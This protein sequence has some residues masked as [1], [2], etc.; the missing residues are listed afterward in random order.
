[1]KIRFLRRRDIIRAL[2][3]PGAIGRWLTAPTAAHGQPY[4]KTPVGGASRVGAPTT[5]PIATRSVFWVGHSLVEQK[6][7]SEWGEIDLPSFVGLLAQD[8]GLPYQSQL[9]ALWGSSIAA[10]WRGRPHSYDRDATAMAAQR[11]NFERDAQRFDTLVLTEVLPVE[12]ALRNEY[13]AYYARQFYCAIKKAN[14]AAKV[15]LYQT[16]INLQ[17]G[18]P[19]AGYPPTERFDWLAE[20]AKQRHVWEKLADEASQ[21]AVR[22]P[23]I[24]DRIGWVSTDDAGCAVNDPIMVAPVGDVF[25]GIAKRLAAPHVT[26]IFKLPSGKDL[27]LGDL[28][29]NPYV[30]WPKEWP[31]S[32]SCSAA[33]LAAIRADLRLRD[34]SKPHDDIHMSLLGIYVAALTHFATLYKQTPVGLRYPIEIGD[35]VA[36]TIQCIVWE[37]V[38]R[39]PRA[40]VDQSAPCQVAPG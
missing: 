12:K 32:R 11:E 33:D 10:L 38:S 30:N 25:V 15:Y 23:T 40:G 3:I 26:D 36:K 28:Y 34:P 21:P 8:R 22:R 16:W 9:H 2:S 6:V 19:G 17:A 35:G 29:A 7:A 18:D 24:L 37:V 39:D 5:T 31:I 13:S 1:M 14:P 27:T 4:N 20:M